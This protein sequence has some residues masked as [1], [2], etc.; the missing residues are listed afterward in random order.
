[1]PRKKCILITDRACAWCFEYIKPFKLTKK[2]E[3]KK[4]CSPACSYGSKALSIRTIEC[5]KCGKP[6]TRAVF[7]GTEPL[8][9]SRE[10]SDTGRKMFS[11]SLCGDNKILFNGRCYFCRKAASTLKGFLERKGF[12]NAQKA[13]PLEVI[14]AYSN[15]IKAKEKIYEC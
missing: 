5:K 9:C 6:F 10:C 12:K 1:M 11:C 15:Y 4:Y 7:K 8:Y 13:L 3:G 2:N 14:I